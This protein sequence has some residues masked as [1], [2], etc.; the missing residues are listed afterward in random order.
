M[1]KPLKYGV[2]KD[3][4]LLTAGMIQYLEEKF[5]HD[6]LVYFLKR[7]AETVYVPLVDEIRSRGLDAIADQVAYAFSHE[8]GLYNFA[9][10]ED[11]LQV[12]VT[13][14]PAVWHLKSKG[15]KIPRSFC[16]QTRVVMREVC[17][18]AGCSFH[19]EF[20]TEQGTCVQTFRMPEKMGT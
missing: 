12:R 16:E 1:D 9:R 19:I 14:C 18:Q 10:T 8:D 7:V 2:H 20:N 4:H 6:E 3:F 13:R 17:R 11:S 15:E 5:G